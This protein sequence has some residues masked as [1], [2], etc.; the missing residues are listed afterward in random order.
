MSRRS[1]ALT[2]ELVRDYPFL[3]PAHANRLAH[4]Y[5]TRAGKLLGNA[6]SI[7]DLGQI[8]RRDLDGERSQI[9]DVGRMGLHRGRHRVAPIQ[10]GI[11]IVIDEIAAIDDWMAANRAAARTI[12]A[13]S[14]RA[15]MTV[16]LEDVTRAVDGIP[17]IR[18]VSLTLS[19]AR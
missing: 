12:P 14:R 9:P 17:T 19:A 16:T 3:T 5:G 7:A 18:D 15:D 1:P 11:A 2:A 10:A 4:A 6:K 8:V 13:G